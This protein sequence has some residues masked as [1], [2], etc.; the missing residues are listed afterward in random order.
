VCN[1]LLELGAQGTSILF[2]SGDSGVSSS[3]GCASKDGVSFNP[4][5]PASCPYVTSVGATKINSAG[6]EYAVFEPTIAPTYTSGGGFSNFFPT[7]SYQQ[8]AVTTYLN[9]YNNPATEPY[10]NAR[11]RGFPDVSSIGA[12]T[13]PTYISNFAAEGCLN[14]P[15]VI[16]CET[17]SQTPVLALIGGTS[18]SSP[19]FASVIALVNDYRINLG[20]S[21]LGFL[22]PAIYAAPNTTFNDITHGFNYGCGPNTLL[23]FNATTGWDPGML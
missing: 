12:I 6:I 8:S 7:P 5:F 23:G 10:F 16:N 17:P 4:D 19:I 3:S 15:G 18:L 1:E 11:G 13:Y 21:P 9:Q 14:G 2:S 22:N 20:K